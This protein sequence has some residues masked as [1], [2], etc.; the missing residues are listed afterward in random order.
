MTESKDTATVQSHL[1]KPLL[2]GIVS[3]LVWKK[4]RRRRPDI[5]VKFKNGDYPAIE[6][7]PKT[8]MD[9]LCDILNR[10]TQLK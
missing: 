3:P 7:L 5:G 2:R 1:F 10:N 9:H 4:I 8:D 6:V